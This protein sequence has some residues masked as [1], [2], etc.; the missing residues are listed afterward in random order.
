MSL[1]VAFLA[2]KSKIYS[3]MLEDGIRVKEKIP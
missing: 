2:E 3:Q 1:R